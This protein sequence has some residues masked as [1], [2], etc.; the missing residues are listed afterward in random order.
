MAIC[1]GPLKGTF[2]GFKDTNT[3]FEFQNG[4]KW[5]Q[6]VYKYQY[7][8][9]SS[10]RAKVV[11]EGGRYILYVDGMGGSVEVRQA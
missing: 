5:K 6:A 8:Y 2:N 10:P 1:E 3:I 7:H 4:R 11:Q 9:A